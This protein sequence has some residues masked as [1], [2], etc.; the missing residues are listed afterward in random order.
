MIRYS[1]LFF[2]LFLFACER[3]ECTSIGAEGVRIQIVNKSGQRAQKMILT[4]P[5]LQTRIIDR[6]I[7]NNAG[8][9]IAYKAAGESTYRLLVILENGDTIKSQGSYAEGGYT[10]TETIRKDSIV[11]SYN[12]YY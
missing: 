3:G 6:I 10:I 12:S 7:E 2:V 9:C 1:F 4:V 11:T 5:P 8:I